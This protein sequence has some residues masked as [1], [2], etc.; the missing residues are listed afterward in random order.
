MPLERDKVLVEL[1][2]ILVALHQKLSDDLIRS[3]HISLQCL[4]F[5]RVTSS[6][7]AN[8]QTGGS[9]RRPRECVV[10]SELLQDLDLRGT[11]LR[12]RLEL[13][14]RPALAP[15]RLA[16]CDLSGADLRGLDLPGW[17]FRDCNLDEA[18]L[19][20]AG[21]DAAVFQGGSARSATF[22]DAD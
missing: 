8:G 21:L 5:P 4:M 1:I 18:R 13:R 10:A 20:G 22:I 2:E 6:G 3:T 12:E 15:L 14:E 17:A 16:R 9:Y 11:S 19:T 7:R